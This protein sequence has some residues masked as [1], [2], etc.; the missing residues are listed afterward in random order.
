MEHR[1]LPASVESRNCRSR[2]DNRATQRNVAPFAHTGRTLACGQVHDERENLIRRVDRAVRPEGQ[3]AKGDSTDRRVDPTNATPQ[4]MLVDVGRG[5]LS[6]PLIA[7]GLH[8]RGEMEARMRLR[9][10]CG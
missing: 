8:W 1:S 4:F 7:F 5:A 3:R 9:Q 6:W 10:E 2:F